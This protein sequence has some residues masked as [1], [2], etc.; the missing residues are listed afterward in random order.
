[1]DKYTASMINRLIKRE[2]GLVDNPDD[3]G[4]KTKY[5][6][7]WRNWDAFRERKY[8]EDPD[9]PTYPEDVEDITKDHARLFYY[10]DYF[11]RIRLPE[12]VPNGPVQE[13]LFD[14]CVHHG[15]VQ[16]IKWLQRAI[17]TKADGIIGPNT[18]AKARAY[19]SN[20]LL[21]VDILSRR[22]EFFGSIITKNK[23]PHYKSAKGWMK[24]MTYFIYR[25]INVR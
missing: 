22:M 17:G 19:K 16:G 21:Y 20:R 4:G 3:P 10:E 1:M 23:H 13:L 14:S 25:T 7:T 8:K 18:I 15:Q 12:A 24:R 9:C 11:T 2:G 5:G 6:V